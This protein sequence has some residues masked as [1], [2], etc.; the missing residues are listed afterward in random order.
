MIMAGF[1]LVVFNVTLF[2]ISLRIQ[3]CFFAF[4]IDKVS[5]FI[6]AIRRGKHDKR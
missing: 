4:C 2:F 3:S 6:T 1:F 5:F